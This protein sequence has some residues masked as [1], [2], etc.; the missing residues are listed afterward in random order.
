MKGFLTWHDQLFRKTH[1]LEEMGRQCAGIDV[2]L[3]PLL[4]CAESLTVC[5]WAFRHPGDAEAPTVEEAREASDVAQEVV[6]VISGRL[7][8]GVRG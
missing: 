3:E 5:A 1:D 7:P 2:S 4:R 8:E 6:E